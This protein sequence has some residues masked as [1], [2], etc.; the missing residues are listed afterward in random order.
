MGPENNKAQIQL[1]KE[2]N[3]KFNKFAYIFEINLFQS[4]QNH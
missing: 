4:K 2:K 1:Y 3:G